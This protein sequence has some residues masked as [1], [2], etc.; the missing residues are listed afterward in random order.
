MEK[1]IER[2]LLFD[3]YGELLTDHQKNIYSE[4][5][6]NDLSL[7]ELSEETG[8]S[9]QGIHDI[10]KRCDKT[11]E[12]YEE[13]LKLINKFNRIKEEVSLLSKKVDSLDLSS[14]D[15]DALKNGL[16]HIIEDL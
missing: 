7:A 12:G 10:I 13:S 3:F 11:L 9:R 6:F 16:Q 5:V 14:D 4:A 15:R 8:I 1:L 2:G